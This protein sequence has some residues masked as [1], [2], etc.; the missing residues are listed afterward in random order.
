MY[1]LLEGFDNVCEDLLDRCRKFIGDNLRTAQDVFN[2]LA[3]TCEDEDDLERGFETEL[4]VKLLGGKLLI[5][6]ISVETVSLK[7]TAVKACL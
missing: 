3:E 1:R 2:L 7:S 6:T 5:P 4:L